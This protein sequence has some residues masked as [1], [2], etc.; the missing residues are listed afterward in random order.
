MIPPVPRPRM[1]RETMNW[2]REK[3]E[4]IS[5]APIKLKRQDTQIVHL[6]PILSPRNVQARAPKVP[7]SVYMAM[8]VPV[9]FTLA[10]GAD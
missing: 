2:A 4:H 8:I 3:D 10:K 5:T 6:R 7:K 1:I 9:V